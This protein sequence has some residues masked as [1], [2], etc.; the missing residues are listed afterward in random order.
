MPV[1]TDGA[2]HLRQ[3]RPVFEQFQNIRRGKKLDSVLCR[4]AER[5]EQ[6]GANENRHVVALTTEHPCCL[7]DGEPRRRLPYQ[8]QKLL[9]IFSH[10]PPVASALESEQVLR[11]YFTR[12]CAK[13]AIQPKN[14]CLDE[15][16]TVRKASD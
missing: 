16:F 10:A 9:L 14:N 8:R 2:R 1:L 15:F 11:K 12:L 13:N 3:P 7:F 6:P 4:V 5:L